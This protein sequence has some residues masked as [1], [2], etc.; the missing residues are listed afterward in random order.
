MNGY[1][2]FP[3]NLKHGKPYIGLHDRLQVAKSFLN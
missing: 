2:Y 1:L 3:N